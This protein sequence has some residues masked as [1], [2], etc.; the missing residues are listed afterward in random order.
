[1]TTKAKATA[2]TADTSA[3]SIKGLIKLV[4]A[5]DKSKVRLTEFIKEDITERGGQIILI[6]AQH[7]CIKTPS[8]SFKNC[9][10]LNSLSR[11]VKR[12]T[13]DDKNELDPVKISRT[14]KKAHICELLPNLKET[15]TFSTFEE[16]RK[17]FNRT[18]GKTAC[19]LTGNETQE[20]IQF[21]GKYSTYLEANS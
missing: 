20:L 9:T 16:V 8:N 3:K 21:L 1:M 13:S 19:N 7:L 5:T 4:E 14:D 12:I 10:R 2:P 18:E 17:L 11:A 6:T 15:K